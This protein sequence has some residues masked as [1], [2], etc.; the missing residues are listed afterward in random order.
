MVRAKPDK[1]SR[2]AVR[3]RRLLGDCMLDCLAL[4]CCWA[5]LGCDCQS[6]SSP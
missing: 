6:C 1:C 3:T 5:V 4:L 2:V